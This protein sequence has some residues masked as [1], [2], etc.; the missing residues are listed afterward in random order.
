[1]LPCILVASGVLLRGVA[2][3]RRLPVLQR[4]AFSKSL[5][6]VLNIASLIT[7]FFL[8]TIAGVVVGGQITVIHSQI[9]TA[10]LWTQVIPFAVVVGAFM[11]AL[12]SLLAA[13]YLAMKA[14]ETGNS[15]LM[16]TFRWRALL[17]RRLNGS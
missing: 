2:L 7:P 12:C 15:R 5:S 10:S 14:E 13:V 3:L 9:V 1:M 16:E 11:L 17:E 6:R 4:Y 8:G